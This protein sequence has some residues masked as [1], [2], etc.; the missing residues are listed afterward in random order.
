MDRREEILK[1]LEFVLTGLEGIQ[2]FFRNR[3]ELSGK[4]RPAILLLDGDEAVA[5]RGGNRPGRAPHLVNMTPEIYVVLGDNVPPGVNVGTEL[6]R[7]K[8]VI[9]KLVFEDVELNG[10]VGSN[11]NIRYDGSVTDL[12]RGRSMEGWLGVGVSFTYV[13]DPRSL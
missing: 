2:A 10:L 8:N 7:W 12:A 11:G 1:R 6:N 5:E 13:F 3:D 9:L 4:R